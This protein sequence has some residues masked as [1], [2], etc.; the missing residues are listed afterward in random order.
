MGTGLTGVRRR[1]PET[2]KRRTRVGIARLVGA[3]I[4][5]E[6]NFYQLPFP[7]PSGSPFGPSMMYVFVGK[8][9]EGASEE[10][11][12]LNDNLFWGAVISVLVNNLVDTCPRKRRGRI[13]GRLLRLSMERLLEMLQFV[14]IC[15]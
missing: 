6:K 3:S 7:P 15:S 9:P 2:S 8:S 11:I 1:N 10:K 14:M 5:F 13:F 4:S 12:S